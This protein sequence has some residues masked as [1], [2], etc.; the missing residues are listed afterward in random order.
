MKIL[1]FT[2]PKPKNENLIVQVDEGNR[3]Y[4]KLHQH[5]EIQLSLILSGDGRLIAGNTVT[6]YAPGDFFAIG[7]NLPHLFQSGENETKSKMISMFFL[8]DCFGK[9]FFLSKEMK[10]VQPIFDYLQYGIKLKSDDKLKMLFDNLTK[11]DEFEV[12]IT[13]LQLLKQMMHSK[14][15]VLNEKGF[16][17]SISSN[18]GER[19]QEVIDYTLHNFTS[20]LTLEKVA[21]KIHMGK[22]SFCRFFKQRTNKT[23]FQFLSEVRINHA[24]QLLRV[25]S[26]LSIAEVALASG[27]ESIS[28]FNRQFKQ[29]QKVNP[30]SFRKHSQS[31]F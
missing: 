6:D 14:K 22:I 28:N 16:V 29:L 5:Q 24:C 27:Y 3:F 26:E 11:K 10:G 18:H 17:Y 13:L 8:K 21:E 19:L 1:P 23:Y 9:D 25:N 31:K 15:E 12:F 2:I 30:S 7:G 4:S 20:N